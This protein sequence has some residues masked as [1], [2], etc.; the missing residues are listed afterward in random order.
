MP[1]CYLNPQADHYSKAMA[2]NCSQFAVRFR[3]IGAAA[4][5]FLACDS[6]P[7]LFA[8]EQ[9][10]LQKAS[11]VQALAQGTLLNQQAVGDAA[12]RSSPVAPTHILYDGPENS[13]VK[14]LRQ[15]LGNL[16]AG[17]IRLENVPLEKRTG[18][19]FYLERIQGKTLI[20]YT[21]KTSLEN[22]IY[23]LLDRWGFRWYGPGENWFV[24]PAAIP[25][26]DIPGQWITPTF[27][28]RSFFGTG[29]LDFS[30]AVA[31][32]PTN[33]FKADWYAW[34][35]RNRFNAD[36]KGT[37]HA[38]TTFYLE[39]KKFLDSHPEWF[40][41]TVGMRAGRIRIEIPEAVAAYKGWAKKRYTKGTASF[42][43]IGVD[44]ED[45][46]GGK[47]DPLPPDGFSGI[48]KWNHADKWWW[49]ANE[50]AKDYPEDESHIVVSMYAY[51]DGPRNALTP[52]FKLRGNVYPIIIP[53]AFQTAYLPPEMVRAW[54]DKVDGKMGL[55]DYWN[56]TQWSQGMPQF[57]I[58]SLPRKLNFW[59]D[60]KVDGIY[61]ETTDAAGPMGHSWWL[62]GQLEFDLE[63]DLSALYQQYLAE[64][65]G[66]AAP[67]MRK[68]YDRWSRHP[69]GPGEVNLSLA[70]LATADAL[71]T[72]DS[73]AWKRI[74]ELKAY[75]HFMMLY[76]A[77]D[78]T[79]AS[80]DRI[81]EYLYSIH[82]LFMVQTAAFMGQHYLAP[83]D[84]GNIIPQ[85]T[86]RRLTAEEIDAQFRAD[87]ASHPKLYDVVDFRF[88]HAKVSYT[89]PMDEAIWRF[90]RNPVAYFI[91]KASGTISFDAGKEAGDTRFIV[92]TD[93]AVLVNDKVGTGNFD[94][95]DT[96]QERTW[97]MKR[98]TLKVEAGKKYQVRFRGGFN[99]FKMRS[100]VVVFNSRGDDDFDNHSYP[101]HYFYVPK[102]C[103][104]IV[105]EETNIKDP[106]GTFFALKPGGKR[107]KSVHGTAL[108]IKG[109][110][111]VEVP[112]EWQGQV[113]GCA[114]GHPGWSLKN[115]PAAF[116]LQ[117]FEYAE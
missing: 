11:P 63:K 96:I 10:L 18:Q 37:G 90:G 47:D 15:V 111:R 102:Q 16:S 61:I 86:A 88:D 3:F 35:R 9:P 60:N 75:V 40:N 53:Y 50:V 84:K 58:Y 33:R 93:D 113:I 54:A 2:Q 21:V 68:M 24:Q 55:Y 73:P 115:L 107:S 66:P 78:R 7:L 74:N 71:V 94:Y 19:E 77:H 117:P 92:F 5:L 85:G 6:A 67:A 4:M 45:G 116:S 82:H 98:Y 28:N 23:T 76:Y 101:V 110:Y 106:T 99:R 48:E 22:A 38:G 12:A 80:K 87:L 79:Q 25:S 91:P 62:A 56:I 8:A 30:S 51:G 1:L 109:L 32:D 81:F 59:R 27:R 108:G 17:E 64:L 112:P 14:D 20:R 34:K 31:F 41:G 52:K 104:E 26:Q 65:F 83:L 89:A 43:E 97:S 57:D 69:Q 39:N 46:R 42:I 70:D 36:F 29:G 100:E 13:A 103:T 95:K 49:L 72:K 44:P 105:F 114:F